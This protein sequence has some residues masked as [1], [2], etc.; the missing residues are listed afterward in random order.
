MAASGPMA[1]SSGRVLVE[2]RPEAK[3]AAFAEIEHRSP[4]HFP[5]MTVGIGEIPAEAAPGSGLRILDDAGAGRTGA[6]HDGD[7]IVAAA[8]IVGQRDP[9]EAALLRGHLGGDVAGQGV[10]RV[11]RDPDAG[12]L[13]EDDAVIGP[14][15]RRGEHRRVEGCRVLQVGHAEGDDGNIGNSHDGPAFR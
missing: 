7:D 3:R 6:V 11:E 4:G 10:Q 9:A 2:T 5:V 14:V 12:Q 15:R 8:R 1:V 13:N